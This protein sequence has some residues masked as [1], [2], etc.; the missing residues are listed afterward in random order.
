MK[1]ERKLAS[2]AA[3][4]FD[5]VK[6]ECLTRFSDLGTLPM[7]IITSALA[8]LSAHTWGKQHPRVEYRGKL[9]ITGVLRLAGDPFEAV[10]ARDT[11]TDYG[12]SFSACVLFLLARPGGHGQDHRNLAIV[13]TATTWIAASRVIVT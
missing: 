8:I 13:A 11:F 2:F 5:D 1:F 3:A 10:D 4:V 9:H 7:N 6:R 12:Y